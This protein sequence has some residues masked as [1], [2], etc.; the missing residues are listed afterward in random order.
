MFSSKF[1]IYFFVFMCSQV[2]SACSVNYQAE[3][4]ALL[5]CVHECGDELMVCSGS[6]TGECSKEFKVCQ[7][8]CYSMVRADL[9]DREDFLGVVNGGP[10]ENK[11]MRRE[12]E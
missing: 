2:L 9:T 4:Q 7:S 10:V 5:A 1:R 12:G 3:G 11:S 6:I 8:D